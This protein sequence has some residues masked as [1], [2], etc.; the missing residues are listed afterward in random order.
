MPK[1]GPLLQKSEIIF[2]YMMLPASFISV[3]GE[4]EQHLAHT[5]MAE[6]ALTHIFFSLHAIYCLH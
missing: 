1:K 5:F 4:G 3:I 6:V 2:A